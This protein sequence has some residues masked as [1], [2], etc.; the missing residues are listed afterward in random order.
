MPAP[1]RFTQLSVPWQVLVRICQSIDY[2]Q[3]LRL[4]V[5]DCEPV[6]D[7][8]PTML[9]DVKLDASED[10]RPELD[11]AD[12]VLRDEIRRLF[13]QLE[14]LRDGTVERIE[15]RSGIPRRVIIERRLTEVPR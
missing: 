15:C 11:L 6:F 5:R 10:A 4:G 7:P 13:A 3:V 14:Q 9:V 8:P 1:E 2:G 12:F